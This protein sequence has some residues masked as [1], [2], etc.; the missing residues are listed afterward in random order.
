[1]AKVLCMEIGSSTIRVAEVRKTKKTVEI[2]K[3][4]MFDT[5]DD[6][7]KDGKVRV[8]DEIVSAIRDALDEHEIQTKDVYFVVESTKILFKQVVDMPF[9]SKNM[10]KSALDLSFTDIFPVDE[11]LYHV[12]YLLEK[13]YE[14]NGQ[15]MMALDV[16]AVPNDLS[17]SYYNLSVA[18]GLNAKGLSDTSRS[19]VSLFPNSFKNRNV[20]MVNINE[21]SSTL[22]IS[23]DGD[24]IFNKTI[25]HGVSDALRQVINS[26]LSMEDTDITNAARFFYTQNILLKQIPTG[27]SDPNDEKEKLQY[28]TTSSI[29]SLVRTIE[30]T[31][32]AFLAKEK[33]HIQEFQ[34]SGLGSGFAGI[35]QLL[36]HEFEIP[37][38]LVQQGG[39]LK[40]HPEAADE[41]LIISCYPSV[42]S[43]LDP[44]NFFTTEEQAGG[45]I[46]HKKKIDQTI[47]FASVLI[48][49]C[50]FGYSSYSWIKTA[51]E[52]QS[53]YDENV[54]LTKRVQ[55]L[56]DLGVETAYNNYTAATSYNEQVMSLYDETRSVNE[57]MT[58][59]LS[60]LESII[61]QSARITSIKMTPTSA[62]VSFTCDNKFVASGVLHLLRNMTTTN[63]M[64]CSGVNEVEGTNEIS[65]NA[66]FILKTTEE[67]GDN[68][69]TTTK[70]DYSNATTDNETDTTTENPMP[71]TDDSDEGL[72]GEA[73]MSNAGSDTSVDTNTDEYDSAENEANADNEFSADAGVSE[74][75]F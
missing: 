36:T 45:E 22:T 39:N 28:S 24:M 42:G 17:E 50:S 2:L 34:L 61:P 58:V 70:D 16:F 75:G 62:Q 14:K 69:G 30:A 35:S 49:L 71:D 3:S 19:M 21:N 25:P 44:I 15:K 60:E 48:C 67:R 66:T 26:P 51:T 20:A 73:G 29:V 6:A 11:T 46:A 31:F 9:V 38:K 23:V 37:V 4:F 12:A 74:G 53:V 57:E 41:E 68:Y 59:F 27:I 64:E 56:R 32:A 72:E 52:K 43:I 13:V 7:T 63:S 33:I 47:L 54:R 18:L 65:F 1:M 5:P 8:S 40:V 10:I 55:E